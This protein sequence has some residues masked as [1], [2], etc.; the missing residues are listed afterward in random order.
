M[1]LLKLNFNNNEYILFNKIQ[2]KRLNI[3]FI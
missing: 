2:L 3:S 1:F